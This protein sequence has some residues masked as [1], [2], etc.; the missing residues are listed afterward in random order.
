MLS[1][2]IGTTVVVLSYLPSDTKKRGVIRA[3]AI[4]PPTLPLSPPEVCAVV[5]LDDGRMETIR[6]SHLQ[7]VP[8]AL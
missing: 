7:V 4:L 3:L 8:R 1:D 2:L 5:Q 6:T